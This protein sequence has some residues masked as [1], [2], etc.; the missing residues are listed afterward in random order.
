MIFM[1]FFYGL[2]KACPTSS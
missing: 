1:V 2:M